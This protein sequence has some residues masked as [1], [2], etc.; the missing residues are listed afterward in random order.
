MPEPWRGVIDDTPKLLLAVSLGAVGLF[1]LWSML[2]ARSPAAARVRR[3]WRAPAF[4]RLLAAALIVL[5]L[6]VI[7]EDVLEA[8]HDEWVLRLD[9]M[10]IRALAEQRVGLRRAAAV[11]SHLTG[12]G[13][14]LL[15]TGALVVL[16]VRHRRRDALILCGAALGAWA[17]SGLFKALL[18]VP[19]PRAGE[20]LHPAASYGFPSGHALVTLVTLGTLAWLLAK[21][22]G[23]RHTALLLAAWTIA[24]GAGASRVVLAAHWPS[25]AVGSLWLIALPVIAREPAAAPSHGALV[26]T[27]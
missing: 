27:R 17:A 1:A 11:V 21:R 15:V 4:R 22:G 8:E 25:D 2:D 18:L 13:L 7:A 19:R 5:A 9:T 24:L 12:E 26:P 10:V 20:V 3:A 16:V 6:A 23:W 14:A